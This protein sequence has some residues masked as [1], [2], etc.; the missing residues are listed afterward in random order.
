MSQDHTETP[1]R[2][3]LWTNSYKLLTAAGIIA[4]LMVAIRFGTGL[5]PMTNMTDVFPWGTWKIFNV[6][7]L[8]ALGSGGYALAFVVYVLN[9]GRYHSLVRHALLTSAVGYTMGVFSLTADIGRP[10]NIWKV[11]VQWNTWNLDSVLLEVAVCVTAYVGVLWIE[12]S[13]AMMEKWQDE[14]HGSLARFSK[15]S[16]PIV[17]AAMPWI[18]GLGLVLPTMHQSSL[19]S[20]Y[21]LAGHKVHELWYTPMIPALFLLSCWILGY[22]MVI[23]TYILFSRR[24]GR[25]TYDVL[26]SRLSLLMGGVIMVFGVMRVGDL[27]WRGQFARLG[28]GSWQSWL[29]ICEL[30]FTFVPGLLLLFDERRRKQPS[31][32][33]RM[34]FMI[35]IGGA[36]YRMDT[37]WLAFD[38]GVNAVYFPS[39]MEL[40]MTTGLIAIQG[41]IYLY[42]VKRFPILSAAEPART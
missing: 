21:L 26:L 5:G 25:P 3:H 28:D 2:R 16:L 19:G 37:A 41:T 22:A 12:M 39:V 29:V 23:S 9:R 35:L 38:G 33:F 17:H 14:G 11:L 18:I 40:I 27:I 6:I 20:L 42:I 31:K 34:S 4:T 36:L 1:I 10:W 15:K 8:T 24:Y 30:V 32:L 13:P 7:V